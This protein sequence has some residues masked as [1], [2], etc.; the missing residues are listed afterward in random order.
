MTYNVFSGTLNPTQSQSPYMYMQ[1]TVFVNRMKYKKSLC[2][3][4]SATTESKQVHFQ[5]YRDSADNTIEDNSSV[6]S[7][8]RM[9]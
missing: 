8:I 1:K 3:A 7:V 5:W 9:R 2:A 4:V 6:F